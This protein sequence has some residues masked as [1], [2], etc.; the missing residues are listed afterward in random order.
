MET[1]NK[2]IRGYKGFDKNLRCRDFQYEIGKEY[3]TERAKLCNEGFHFC[4]NPHN[5]LSYYSAGEGNRFAVVE[6]SEVSDEK[7]TILRG[8]QKE[9]PSR[10]RYQYSRYA[11]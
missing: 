8:C 7:G 9:S 10:R 11:G 6:T 1:E 4:E 2:T 3:E 5:V